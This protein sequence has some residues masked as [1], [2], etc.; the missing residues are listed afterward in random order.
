MATPKL[1]ELLAQEKEKI[2]EAN[3]LENEL[4]YLRGVL[5]TKRSLLTRIRDFQIHC[6][7]EMAKLDAGI[8]KA[9]D[10]LKSY[11]V[12]DKEIQELIKL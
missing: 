10:T 3:K 9:V 2:N 6:N 12:P 5:N 1:N 11:S 7:D 8:D 4:I